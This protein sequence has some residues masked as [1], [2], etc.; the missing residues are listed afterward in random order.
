M[1]SIKIFFS[2]I[3]SSLEVIFGLIYSYLMARLFSTEIIGYYGAIIA[4]FTTLA[5]IIDLGF[6]IAHLKF[7]SETENSNEKSKCNGAFLFF[8]SL[9]FTIY[10]TISLILIPLLGTYLGEAGVVFLLF[11]GTTLVSTQYFFQPLLYSKKQVIKNN[12]AISGAALIRILLII[13]L[14]LYFRNDILFLSYIL[15]I[16]NIFYISINLYF[17]RNTTISK[18]SI[19]HLKKYFKYAFPF[20]I[21]TSLIII[22]SNID[23]LFLRFWDYS[24]ADIGN[25][26]MAKKFYAYIFIFM[27]GISN[28][29]ITTFS[30]N[31]F[32]KENKK[33]LSIIEDSHKILNVI[34]VPIVMIIVLYGVDLIVFVFGEQYRFMGSLLSILCFVLL[35]FS[36]NIAN[37]SQLQALGEV[38]MVA[39]ITI[40]ENIIAIILMFLFISPDFFRFGAIGGAL[41]IVLA[42]IIVQIIFRPILYK[43]FNLKFYFGS[44]R[45]VIIMIG[46][47]FMQIGIK[48]LFNY[49]DFFIPIFILFDVLI[50]FVI[51]YILKG[52]NRDDIKYIL[53]ILSIKNIKDVLFLELKNEE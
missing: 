45:N 27:N 7:Y 47:I 23:I 24:E 3:G 36:V 20:F 19:E 38:K 25:Y 43:K 14:T 4:F 11:L 35:S 8:K 13:S 2:I 9:Q 52:I 31:I 41:A 29:L 10:F 26:Y 53:S 42:S 22:V 1:D 15:L 46:V 37:N 39:K 30:K 40:T 50:Y 18:P 32:V 49:P 28:I 34:T 51:N 21:T 5:F 44:F 6:S 12:I 16:S 17:I 48:F 33:N